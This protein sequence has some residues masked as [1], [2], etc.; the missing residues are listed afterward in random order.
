[1]LE[2]RTTINSSILRRWGE[3]IDEGSGGGV[4]CGGLVDALS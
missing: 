3:D 2:T 1:M 4:L